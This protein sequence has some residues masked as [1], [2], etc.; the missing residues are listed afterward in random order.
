MD[1]E[2]KNTPTGENP[3]EN[4]AHEE[5]N[6]APVDSGRNP[7]ELREMINVLSEQVK[8]LTEE[9]HTKDPE[10]VPKADFSAYFKDFMK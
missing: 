7:D 10:S 6:T 9:L 1:E 2:N 4:N 8:A 5:N 3:E